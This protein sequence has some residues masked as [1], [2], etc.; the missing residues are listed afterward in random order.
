MLLNLLEILE[1]EFNMKKCNNCNTLNLDRASYC[2]NCK[3]SF[4]QTYENKQNINSQLNSKISS[5]S[6]PFIFRT[7]IIYII[8]F[9]ILILA[10]IGGNK[11][12][13]IQTKK[14]SESGNYN[15]SENWNNPSNANA[16]Y[17]TMEAS[18][19]F[20]EVI[21]YAEDP[22]KTAEELGFIFD[23]RTPIIPL[24]ISS[25]WN[26][27]DNQMTNLFTAS[28]NKILNNDSLTYSPIN[29]IDNNITTVWN[30]GEFERSSDRARAISI[31]SISDTPWNS[32]YISIRVGALDDSYLTDENSGINVTVSID[33]YP[34]LLLT[35]LQPG[36]TYTYKISDIYANSNFANR[37]VNKLDVF[38]NGVTVNKDITFTF[39][40]DDGD[41]I[42]PSNIQNASV[43]IEE[44]NIY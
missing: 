24:N 5:K 20:Y 22:R 23:Y 36:Q 44:I 18:G 15:G 43:Y 9:S 37:L 26:F 3:T 14:F 6:R 1:K 30:P 41:E 34:E 35:D 10:I 39:T 4:E 13:N 19:D 42:V 31:K 25:D 32:E 21:Y 40:F 28:T 7:S 16:L 17:G 11:F 38:I 12:Y 27:S 8:I 29:V 2:R 33:D